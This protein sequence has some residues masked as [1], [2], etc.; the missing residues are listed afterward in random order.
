MKKI[1]YLVPLALLS[2][3]QSQEEINQKR[4]ADSTA[5][6]I[7]I[8]DSIKKVNDSILKADANRL[9]DSIANVLKESLNEA[10]K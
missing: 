3:G 8:S 7:V 10:K 9:A 1:I 5:R 4:I 2:C 6:A